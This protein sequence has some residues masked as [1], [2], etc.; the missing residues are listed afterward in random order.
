MKDIHIDMLNDGW[1]GDPNEY[2]KQ[3]IKKNKLKLINHDK[4]DILC[5]NCMVDNLCPKD[6][7]E[8]TCVECGFDFIKISENTVRYK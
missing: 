5:P 3:Y 6:Q 1:T 2:L 8:L 7:D 4:T